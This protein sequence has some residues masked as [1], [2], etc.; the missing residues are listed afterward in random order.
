[1][2]VTFQA[3]RVVSSRVKQVWVWAAGIFAALF[4]VMLAGPGLGRK[5]GDLRRWLEPAPAAPEADETETEVEPV[6][7]AE[8]EPEPAAEQEPEQEDGNQ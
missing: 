4:M 2:V 7:E 3:D 5:W 8:M 6:P 1:M